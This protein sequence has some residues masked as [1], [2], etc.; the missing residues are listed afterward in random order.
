MPRIRVVLDAC[1]LLP[2]Q[3]ADLLLRLADAELYEPLWSEAILEEVHRNL[4]GTFGVPTEKATKRLNHMRSAFPNANVTGYENLMDTMTTEPKDRHVAAAAVRGNAALIVTANIRDFPPDALEPYDIEVIHPDDFLQDQLDLSPAL[5]LECLQRQRTEYTRPQFT[6]TEFYLTLAK[7]VPEFATRAATAERDSLPSEGPTP[8]EIVSGAAAH[9]AFF[10]D[11]EPDATDPL[12]AAYLWWAALQ[13]RSEL[14]DV[15]K[16]LTYHPPAWGNYEWADQSLSGT[17]LMQFVERC[18]DDDTIVYVKFMP[19]V[20]HAMRAFGEIP[21]D[22]VR[23]LTM[24]RCPDGLWRAW[25]LSH[26]HFPSA[27]EVH[28]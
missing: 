13:D 7:T 15:L 16:A 24:V 2:Y 4:I 20:D 12:G 18:P 17:G 11:H 14:N 10:P 19:N 23:I 26:N 27:V 3:L 8:L 22:D 5:T 1:V 9:Q 28:G 6:F 25:G 21:L